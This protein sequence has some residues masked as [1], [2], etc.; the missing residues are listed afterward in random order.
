MIFQYQFGWI[1]SARTH[2]WWR[3]AIEKRVIAAL[4]QNLPLYD[5]VTCPNFLVFL[6]DFKS[7][8]SYSDNTVE[9]KLN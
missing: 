3:P 1:G 5:F 7:I 2:L 6:Q 9:N 8:V 4:N